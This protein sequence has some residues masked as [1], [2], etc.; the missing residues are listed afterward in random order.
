MPGECVT[1][2]KVLSLQ[3]HVLKALLIEPGSRTLETQLSAELRKGHL[4]GPQR[5]ALYY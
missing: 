4:L 2:G 3:I 5:F 1:E